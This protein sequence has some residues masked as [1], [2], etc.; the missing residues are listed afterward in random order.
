[1]LIAGPAGM[2]MNAALIMELV[3]TPLLYLWQARIQRLATR[4]PVDA[5]AAQG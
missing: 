1:M 3:V 5:A 4:A 2:A